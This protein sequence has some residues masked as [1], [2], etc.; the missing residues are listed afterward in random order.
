MYKI[1]IFNFSQSIQSNVSFYTYLFNRY[2]ISNYYLFFYRLTNCFILSFETDF[3]K[4][5]LLSWTKTSHSNMLYPHTWAKWGT[6]AGGEIICHVRKFR[7]E[8]VS[9]IWINLIFRVQH[10]FSASVRKPILILYLTLSLY[11]STSTYMCTFSGNRLIWN[12]Q[13]PSCLPICLLLG[14]IYTWVKR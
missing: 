13:P 8:F 5:K 14:F 9:D 7:N 3:F 11:I 12:S 6:S 4:T 10:A 2:P 1:N